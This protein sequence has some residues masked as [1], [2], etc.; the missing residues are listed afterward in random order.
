MNKVLRIDLS[1]SDSDE[2]SVSMQFQLDDNDLVNRFCNLIES[3]NAAESELHTA[4]SMTTENVDSAGLVE[5]LDMAISGFN[6]LN[7]G[8]GRITGRASLDTLSVDQLNHFHDRFEFYM[9]ALDDGKKELVYSENRHQLLAHLNDVNTYVHKL[10]SYLT[11]QKDKNSLKSYFTAR[12]RRKDNKKHFDEKLKIED[13]D[14][15][16]MEEKFGNLYVNYATTGKNLQQIYWSNDINLLKRPDGNQ[17]Q[18]II[19]AGII[20]LFNSQEKEHEDELK[21]FRNWAES[22][23]ISQYGIDIDDPTNGIGMLKIG[24]LLPTKEI[25]SYFD[26]D[27]GKFD[28]RAV[29][30]YF[31]PYSVIERMVVLR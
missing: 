6:Q 19:T 1:K 12:Y 18:R 11:R 15:F 2:Q 24:K 27:S 21:T 16:T 8:I 31:S 23:N 22:I 28:P 17:P 10:E 14:Q 5:K 4:W 29:V 7:E 25:E 3:A 9:N 20:A 30:N 13:Y 26:M